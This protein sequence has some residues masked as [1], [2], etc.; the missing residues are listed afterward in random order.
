M[1]ILYFIPPIP[2]APAA[3]LL[4]APPPE[5]EPEDEGPSLPRPVV[6]AAEEVG[7]SLED[8]GVLQPTR[9]KVRIIAVK[10]MQ[11]I[12]G[13]E[14]SFMSPTMNT[15]A[16][17]LFTPGRPSGSLPGVICAGDESRGFDR[18]AASGFPDLLVQG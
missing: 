18:S 12:I 15:S 10:P 14:S 9:A 1:R 5:W 6:C 13:V 11:R 8:P 16:P 4:P 17:A 3:E 2:P 7:S